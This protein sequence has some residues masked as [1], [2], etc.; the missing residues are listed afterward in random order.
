MSQSTRVKRWR[1][2]RDATFRGDPREKSSRH[3]TS[4]PRAWTHSQRWPPTN[5]APPVTSTLLGTAPP[6]LQ[7]LRARWFR[8][9]MTV[10]N[11][12]AHA[13]ESTNRAIRGRARG[14]RS[15]T[16]GV[17]P[18]VPTDSNAPLR[19]TP[20]RGPPPV[21]APRGSAV[22]WGGWAQR[23][24][25]LETLGR[26]HWAAQTSVMIGTWPRLTYSSRGTWDAA[27]IAWRP[28]WD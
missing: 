1:R 20:R 8:S 22:P 12:Y 7:R 21:G 9:C 24:H 14:G 2:S 10:R 11:T 19:R 13:T 3:T 17:E 26:G 18:D 16:R 25:R 23:R 4:S 6:D 27:I 15:D 28:P 5:P